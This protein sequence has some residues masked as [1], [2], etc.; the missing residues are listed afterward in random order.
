MSAS[1]AIIELERQAAALRAEALQLR[2]AFKKYGD[3]EA[4][5]L[6]EMYKYDAP[7]TCGFTIAIN[8]ARA[9]GGE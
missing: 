7:C 5:C 1:L 8:A 9:A 4:T 3:H 2:E 6:D